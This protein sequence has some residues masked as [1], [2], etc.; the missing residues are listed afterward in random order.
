M[1]VR[2]RKNLAS[3]LISDTS[4]DTE[5]IFDDAGVLSGDAN[6]T[7]TKGTETVGL[8]NIDFDTT[9][10]VTMQEGRTA[11]DSEHGTLKIGMPGGKVNLQVG[12][13]G[14]VHVRNVTGFTINNGDLVYANGATGNRLTIALADNTDSDKIQ[15]LGMATENINNNRNGYVA[16]WGTVHGDAT[17]PIDTSL[18]S[19]GTKLYMNAAG[20]WTSSHPTNPTYAT[21]VIGIVERSHA[22]EGEISLQVHPFTVGNDFDGT[23]RQ[24]VIN[25]SAGTSAACGFTAVNNSGHFMTVG[26]GGTNNTTFADNAIY[27]GPGYNDNLYACDG[28]KSHKWF[29]DPGDNH[30]NSSLNFLN[31][32]LS[33]LGV[34]SLPISLNASEGVYTDGS[35]GLTSTIPTS[36]DLGFWNRTG[37]LLSPT[38]AGDS[39]SIGGAADAVQLA[40]KANA[41]QSVTNPHISLQDSSGTVLGKVFTDGNNTGLGR[42]VFDSLT[43]G[44]QNYG[45]GDQALKTLT[46]G[47]SNTALGSFSLSLLLSGDENTSVGTGAMQNASTSRYNT[48]IGKSSLARHTGGDLNTSIGR[49]ALFFNLTG[50]NNTAVG[51][52]AGVNCTG[53]SNVFLGKDVAGGQVAIS[54]Q[55]WIDNSNTSTPLIYGEFDNDYVRVYGDLESDT[56]QYLDATTG[57]TD[58]LVIGEGAGNIGT[59]TGGWGVYL[60]HN[61]GS[62]ITSAN[63]CILIGSGAGI[64]I[65]EGTGNISLGSN[66]SLVLTTGTGNTVMGTNALRANAT[67]LNNVALGTNACRNVTNVNGNLGIGTSALFTNTTG[68]ENIA[69]GTSTMQDGATPSLN[70]AI[71]ALAFL[72][73]S[74]SQGVAIGYNT[75]R[76][77]TGAGNTFLGYN[78]GYGVDG[79]ST[80]ANNIGIGNQALRGLTTGSGHVS[81]GYLSGNKLTTNWDCTNIGSTSGRFNTGSANVFIGSQSGSGVNGSSTGGSNVG[82]GKEALEGLTTASGCVAIGFQAGQLLTTGGNNTLIGYQAGQDLTG[83]SNVMIGYDVADAQTAISNELWIANTNTSSPLVHG[84]FSTG[85]LRINGDLESDAL[86]YL[87]ATTGVTN[88]ILIGELSGVTN[89]GSY[90]VGLGYNSLNANTGDYC[91]GLGYNTLQANTGDANVALG[92]TALQNNTSGT[93]NLGLGYLSVFTNTTGS[94]NVGVG[95]S[96]LRFNNDG[97]ENVAIGFKAMEDNVS[98][99]YSVAIGHESLANS[100]AGSNT[101]IGR[102]SAR[103]NITGTFNT[104]I[105]YHASYSSTSASY[106]TIVGQQAGNTAN[107]GSNTFMGYRTGFSNTGS[108]NVF[109]GREAGYN[110][111]GSNKLYIENSNSATPL[112]YGEFDNDILKVHGETYVVDNDL[113]LPKTS[114]KGIKVDTTTPTFGWRDILGQIVTKGVGQSDPDWAVFRDTLYQYKFTNGAHAHEAWLDFHIPHDYVPGTDIYIHVHWAQNVVDTG[115]AASVPGV[116]KWYWDLSYADGYGTPGGAGDPFVT[117][118]TVSVTQ[119]ASTTQYAHMIAEVVISGATDTAST[120]DRTVFEVDGMIKAR[121]YRDSSDAADTLDQDPFVIMTD[122]H[123]QSTNMA[124]KDKNTPFYT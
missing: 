61:A 96:S 8:D 92:Y 90:S 100:T 47:D 68:N 22:T 55:L 34:L 78:V 31:M 38:T 111:T 41:S 46:I 26:I 72:K 77:N 12:Q 51:A 63:D 118:K 116:S 103:L 109:L 28:N 23:M 121:I 106:N 119:Q 81:I 76:F 54:N 95:S 24:S 19:E 91:F 93:N 13:E 70:V 62:A 53:S 48:A 18:I 6:F 56:L 37:T 58:T 102:Y 123:Y 29:N 75:G 7:Y 14:L 60:G 101:A 27:Y 104:S 40:I 15:I 105:G 83:S 79:S 113:V 88:S 25:K 44:I 2:G 43:T 71:G 16:I 50:S 49:N 20:G 21:I 112:I 45:I 87:D 80:G 36:G 107:S 86:K 30:N 89:S 42:F 11:W 84:N 117:V 99:N 82:I 64:A 69:I 52:G 122:I 32:E 59:Q 115:G 33:P 66:S 9:S 94:N 124:T 98:G 114:G 108:F 3:T 120:F 17:E 85:Y 73:N 74:S 4:L 5:V 97:A 110:E 39:V 1:P 67:G 57:V 65:T 35:S 10:T